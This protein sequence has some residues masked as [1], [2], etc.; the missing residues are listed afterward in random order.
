M[1]IYFDDKSS[2]LAA[3]AARAGAKFKPNPRQRLRKQ[4]S[5]STS[6]TL[7]TDASDT[8]AFLD[9]PI[10]Q[11][12]EMLLPEEEEELVDMETFNIVQEG[13]NANGQHTEKLKPKRKL[14]GNVIEEQNHGVNKEACEP[15][16]STEEIVDLST[17]PSDTVNGDEPRD[18]AI[19]MN[20]NSY[21]DLHEEIFPQVSQKTVPEMAARNSSR[22]LEHEDRVESASSNTVAGEN[23]CIAEE[24]SGR[25]RNVRKSRRAEAEKSRAAQKRKKTSDEPNQCSQEP[26]KKKFKHSTP[27]QKRT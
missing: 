22:G 1:D 4:A 5:V 21:A 18:E 19:I 14:H 2:D 25:E 24:Q 15:H 9:D 13:S 17:G 23:G 10:T 3:T 20:A 8:P 26:Q 11:A 27:R 16:H 6:R 12:T 7:S